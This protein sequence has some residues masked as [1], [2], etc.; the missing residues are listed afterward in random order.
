MT[1]EQPLVALNVSSDN[2]GE[3]YYVIGR[4]GVTAIEWGSTNGHMAALATVRVF[5]GGVLSSEH[6]FCNVFGV[7]Y[8]APKET[9]HDD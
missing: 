3:E 5:K 1:N 7:Y 6:P 4:N 2:N 9:R 8:A